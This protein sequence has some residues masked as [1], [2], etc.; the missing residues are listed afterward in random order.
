MTEETYFPTEREIRELNRDFNKAMRECSSALRDSDKAIFEPAFEEVSLT[1]RR[2]VDAVD[3]YIDGIRPGD[4][5]LKVEEYVDRKELAEIQYDMLK[6]SLKEARVS[7]CRL[8]NDLRQTSK[9]NT[10]VQMLDSSYYYVTMGFVVQLCFALS[11]AC[12]VVFRL[13]KLSSV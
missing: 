8:A 13:S 11:F 1:F 10:G 3:S 12:T 5:Q 2:L 6:K 4:D 9:K 7:Q